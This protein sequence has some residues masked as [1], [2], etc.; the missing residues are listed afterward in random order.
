M[1][2]PQWILV[3]GL[4]LLVL[5]ASCSV[6]DDPERQ[7]TEDKARTGAIEVPLDRVVIDHVTYWD[8]DRTDWKYFTVPADGVARV[9][10]YFDNEDAR[11]NVTVTNEV[12]QIMSR[13]EDS[14]AGFLRQLSFQA[15]PG[16]Y[17]VHLWAEEGATDYS[18]EVT[19]TST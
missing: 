17:Y 4:A 12:G 2:H 8:G 1:R 15:A 10:V 19:F 14:E 9:I 3:A 11:P 7:S 6:E 16:N 13:L 5:G 18:L